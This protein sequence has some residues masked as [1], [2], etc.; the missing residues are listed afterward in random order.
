MLKADL[1]GDLTEWS[2]HFQH[3]HIEGSEK[4]CLVYFCNAAK[5][6]PME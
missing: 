6:S 1:D 3:I 2:E 4:P 5:I